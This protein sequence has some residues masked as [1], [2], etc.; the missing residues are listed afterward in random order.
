MLVLSLYALNLFLQSFLDKV[1]LLLQNKS[2]RHVFTPFYF[3]LAA[4]LEFNCML[5]L[6]VVY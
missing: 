5:I 6:I 1:Y 3:L 4:G 2:L